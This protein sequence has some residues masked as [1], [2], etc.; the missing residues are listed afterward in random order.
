MWEIDERVGEDAARQWDL[1]RQ[2]LEAVI[3]SVDSASSSL[4]PVTLFND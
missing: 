4:K 1:V 3:Y 2:H